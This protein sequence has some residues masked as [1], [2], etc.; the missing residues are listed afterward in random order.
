M[1]ECLAYFR[2][3]VTDPA[4]AVPWSDWWAAN[5]ELVAQVFPLV[6]FVR[7]KHRRL[8]GAREILIRLGELTADYRSPDPLRSGICGDC[9]ERVVNHV[10]GPGG[11]TITCPNCGLLF[12]YDCGPT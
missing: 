4:S 9:G 12:V 10:A 8:R 5:S 3:A 6:E 2:L 1:E 11:G 7:L